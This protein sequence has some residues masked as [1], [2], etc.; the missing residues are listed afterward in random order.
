[1]EKIMEIQ[2]IHI[3]I[4]ELYMKKWEILRKLKSLS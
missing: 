4:L 3:I 2:Q 1:M